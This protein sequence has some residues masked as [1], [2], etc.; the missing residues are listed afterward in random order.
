MIA[1][2]DVNVLI[3]LAWP[4]HIFHATARKWL[5]KQK[6]KGWATC[7]TTE[8]GF[9]RISSNPRI[10]PE[11]KSP[12]EAARLVQQLRRIEGH[13]FW[14]EE[15]SLIDDRWVP[16]EKIHTCHQVTDAHLLSLAMRNQG[17]LATFDR[18]ILRILPDGVD[19]KKVIQVLAPEVF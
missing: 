9:I 14:N 12:G 2:L 19:A 10:T 11:Y 5:R 17:R 15:S 8:N 3:A 13:V 16:L 1:L 4:N 18:G 7:P 6:T